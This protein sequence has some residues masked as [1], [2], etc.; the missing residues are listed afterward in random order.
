MPRK[1]GQKDDSTLSPELRKKFFKIRRDA[2]DLNKM[3]TDK[4]ERIKKMGR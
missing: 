2:A 4:A 3:L 1:K